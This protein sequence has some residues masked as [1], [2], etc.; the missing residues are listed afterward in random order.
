[1]F[2]VYLVFDDLSHHL[3]LKERKKLNSEISYTNNNISIL[4][5]TSGMH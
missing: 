3:E 1:M 2:L 5:N 4:F